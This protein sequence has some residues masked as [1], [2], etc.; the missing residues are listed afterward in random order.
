MAC[1]HSFDTLGVNHFQHLE[2]VLFLVT[3]NE[4]GKIRNRNDYIEFRA[5]FSAYYHE[6]KT[7]LSKDVLMVHLEML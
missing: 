2:G 6:N 1:L 4:K 7:T 3:L 5:F